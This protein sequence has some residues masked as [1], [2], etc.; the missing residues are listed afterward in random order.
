MAEDIL[1]SWGAFLMVSWIVFTV[2]NGIRRLHQQ[3]ML[4]QFQTK[5]LDRIGSVDELGAFLN[6][7]PGARFL[8]GLT[9]IN[10]SAGPQ[11]RI[12]RAVQS[13]AVL[14]TLGI[15]LYLYGWMTPT[16][17]GEVTNS[18]NA[19][20]TIFFG[21]G[22]GFLASAALSYRLSKQMGLLSSDEQP[23]NEPA[24]PAI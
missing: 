17:P 13:G 6:T 21:I 4:S 7:E 11:I 1:I 15:G 14:A 5:L 3:R 22:A 8:K 20:A 16:I 24:V 19:L 18:I 12:L 9:T 23:R 2:V 10:E